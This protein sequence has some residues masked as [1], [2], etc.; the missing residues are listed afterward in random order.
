[1]PK[2]SFCHSVLA[3]KPATSPPHKKG[4]FRLIFCT[5]TSM[6]DRR[7]DRIA[8]ILSHA[9]EQRMR[10]RDVLVTL[11][12]EEHNQD[13]AQSSVY[14]AIKAEN[15][16]LVHLGERPQFITSSEGEQSGWVHLETHQ[17]FAAG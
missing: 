17:E 2:I 10:I 3:L 16:R 8:K 14:I 11:R 7:I 12:T 9:D 1:M 6:S 4:M 5:I 13:I 15:K